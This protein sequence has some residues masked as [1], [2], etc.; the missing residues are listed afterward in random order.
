MKNNLIHTDKQISIFQSWQRDWNKFVRDVLCAKLDKEQQDII[1]SVQVNS[2]TAVA[3]E[4]FCRSVCLVMLY[5]FNAEVQFKR[6][7]DRK[8]ESCYDSTNRATSKKHYDP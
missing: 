3:R 7:N 5:V 4:R 2:M 1:R 6:C 8:H